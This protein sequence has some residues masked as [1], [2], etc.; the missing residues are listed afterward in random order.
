[1]LSENRC[2]YFR[3]LSPQRLSSARGEYS[4]GEQ[5]AQRPLPTTR[6]KGCGGQ[7]TD[8]PYLCARVFDW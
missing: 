8:P 6:P 2:R 7:R 1:M 3:E 4:R 5:A